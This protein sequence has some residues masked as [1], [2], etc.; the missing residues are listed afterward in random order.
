VVITALKDSAGEP[1][2]FAAITRDISS[3]KKADQE[4]RTL[5]HELELHVAELNTLNK[6]LEAFSYSVSHDLRM[7]L[8]HIDGFVDLLK[9]ELAGM[10]NPEGE[11]YMKVISDSAKHMGTLI[12][13]LLF[14]SRMSRVELQKSTVDPVQ[15]VE[16]TIRSLEMET[17]GREID[18]KIGILPPLEADASLMRLVFMN[19]ISNA[20]KFTRTRSRAVIE[21]GHMEYEGRKPAYF[22]RDNGVGFDMEYAD[23]LFGVFQRLHTVDKF[24][25]TGIGLANVRRIV[26]RHGGTTWG[27]GAVEK[28][29]TFYFSLPSKRERRDLPESQAAPDERVSI[30]S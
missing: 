8:R 6:E 22:V 23:K 25:G 24:E 14:F 12:D 7:P 13:D 26:H 1:R 29:A 4:L 27:E 15:I 18:W 5:A 3:R 17:R 9:A 30:I 28:G 2:G 21:I 16:E 19:L 10:L 20:L 11:H